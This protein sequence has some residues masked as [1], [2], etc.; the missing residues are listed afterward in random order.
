M[1]SPSRGS[2]SVSYI[3]L[4][5]V[6]DEMLDEWNTWH[7]T[8]HIPEVLHAPQIRGAR[9][10][11]VTDNSFGAEWQPQYATVYELDSLAD[12]ESYAAGPGMALRQAYA[13][14]YGAVGKIARM[15]LV[16]EMLF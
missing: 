4:T 1:H 14:R 15:V 9:K 16:E 6:P 5:W 10:F 11:R 2:G 7:N 13:D 8:I 3:V 12:M